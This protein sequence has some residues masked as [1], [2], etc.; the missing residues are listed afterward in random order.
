MKHNSKT[1]LITGAAGFIGAFLCKKLLDDGGCKVV[2]LDNM[3][4][5]Y[6]PGIKEERLRMLRESDGGRGSSPRTASTS[7]SIWP[8]RRACATP[9][10][11]RVPTSTP[12]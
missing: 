10:T 12:T 7:W 2:G 11:T 5:Y 6:D 9:S 3:N 1:V 4:S 8:P